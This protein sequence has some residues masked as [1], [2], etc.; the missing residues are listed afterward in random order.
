M[1]E[2]VGEV[3]EVPRVGERVERDHLVIGVCEQVANERG[4]DEP[5]SAGDE[6]ALPHSSLSIVYIGLPSTSSLDSAQILADERKDE[7]L[8]PEHEEQRDAAEERPGEVRL[9]DPVDDAVDPEPG[10]EQG[11]DQPEHDADPL[12]RLRPEARD[13]VEREPDEA[14]RGV[15]GGVV[16]RRV[17]DVHLDHARAAGEDQRLRELLAADRAEHRH[18][19][20]AA[21]GVEG[22]AEVGDV[23]LR[24]AAEHPVDQPRGQRP[25]PRVAPGG[26]PAA[27]DVAAGL[28]RG[29]EARDV[30]GRV[31]EV[32]VHRHHD[33]AAGAGE[34][35]VHRRVLAGV[36]LEAHGA[37]ARVGLVQAL[38][39]VEAAVRRAVVDEDQLVVLGRER[40]RGA[41]IE[42]LD[43]RGLVVDG[44]DHGDAR[45]GAGRVRLALRRKDVCLRHFRPNKLQQS[46]EAG[47]GFTAPFWTGPGA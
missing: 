3:L 11:A 41:A 39:H 26:A 40:R 12:D 34:A 8:D 37:D 16:A 9:G 33:L 46:D 19:D 17:R 10:R 44:D 7:A 22:A 4:G 1:R 5:G 38:E 43:R 18:D 14:K 47:L 36:A 29:D 32:A 30:L 24:E 15:A 13:D 2:H 21:V 20:V 35:R 31:L 6:H 45:R 25:A 23:D 27:R 42:L 28:D